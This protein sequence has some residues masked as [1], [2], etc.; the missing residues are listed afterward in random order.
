MPSRRTFLAL[1]ATAA[2]AG[3]MDTAQSPTGSTPQNGTD[4]S[5]GESTP[6]TEKAQTTT[7]RASAEHVAWAQSLSGA[8]VNPTTPARDSVYVGTDAG[9][10]AALSPADGTTQWTYD[11]ER[12]VQRSPVVGD[13]TVLAIAGADGLNSAHAAHAIDAET[14]DRRWTFSPT[15]WWLDVVGTDGDTAYVATGDDHVQSSGQTLYA[16]ALGDG[17]ERWAAE[18]GDPS[19]GLVT[20]ERVYVPSYGVLYAVGKDGTPAWQYE[21]GEYQFRTLSVVDDTV[22]FVDAEDPRE[23]TVVAL[24]RETG[25]QRWSFEEWK[26]YTTQAVGDRLLVGGDSVASLDPTTGDVEWR[27]DVPATIYD[28]PVADGTLYVVNEDAAAISLS[29]GSVEWRTPVDAYLARPTCLLDGQLVIQRSASQDDRDRHVL[30]LDAET[31][32]SAWSY[33]AESRLTRLVGGE[34][35]AFAGEDETVLAIAP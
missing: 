2:V 12:K 20:D 17:T 30:A 18:I 29:D 23:P 5:G 11:A 33:A 16:L 26:A 4:G 7:D 13:G 21:V 6:D 10:V 32:E 22:A 8:V 24:D 31:G 28:T 27:A 34:A 19:G 1:S 15:D 9:T 3:C 14:G 35:Y 25:E